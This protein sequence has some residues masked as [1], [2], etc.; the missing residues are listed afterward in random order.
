MTI[1]FPSKVIAMMI[2]RLFVMFRN[3]PAGRDFDELL[4]TAASAFMA[5]HIIYNF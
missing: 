3:M 4:L 1:T 2:Q 5:V